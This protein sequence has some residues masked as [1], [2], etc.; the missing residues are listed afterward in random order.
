MAAR[1][2]VTAHGAAPFPE[3]CDP[4]RHLDSVPGPSITMASS[5]PTG[6]YIFGIILLLIVGLFTWS[7]LNK[8]HT[9]SRRRELIRSFRA[10]GTKVKDAPILV[11]G[12][13]RA[14]DILLPTTGEHVAYYC[15]FI[16]SRESA[17]TDTRSGTAVR[18]NGI[19]VGGE[20][21]RID[22]VE[23]FHFFETSG[24]FTVATGL[25]YYFVRPSSI[26]S[27]F[28]KGADLVAGFAGA[29]VEKTG[30]PG[31][32]FADAM[33]FEVAEQ[34]LS[35]LCRFHAPV[36]TERSR[37]YSSALNGKTT[38]QR[39][40]VSVMTATSWIDSRV[41]QFVAGFNLPQGIADLIAK[42]GITLPEKEEVIVIEV[43]IPLNRDVF[44]FGTFDGDRSIVFTD[45]TVQ[46]TVSYTD[47]ESL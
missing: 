21:T 19:P 45:N 17:I 30:L 18:V 7:F 23:G 46:L 32:V 35:V 26:T 8:R 15:L 37:K 20:Q 12:Q 38:T 16:L 27:Y 4:K 2:P 9:A 13:A 43:F 36:V 31:S 10:S 47:P 39:T 11:K 5:Y 41:H 14:P 33:A 3:N 40:T 28:K 44:V 42:R 29:H 6:L 22:S 25:A 24:D 1:I 34:A